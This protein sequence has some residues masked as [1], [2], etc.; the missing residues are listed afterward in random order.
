MED[1]INDI[2]IP[3]NSILTNESIEIIT[4]KLEEIF[5]KGIEKFVPTLQHNNRP[6]FS[7]NTKLIL[8]NIHWHRNKLTRNRKGLNCLSIGKHHRDEIH[9]LNNLLKNSV[10]F[11]LNNAFKNRLIDSNN[12]RDIFQAVK[13]FTGHKKN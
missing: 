9:L 13:Q 11:D 12:S 10:R 7:N 2:N 6:P 1:E 4:M 8:K 3:S 5:R